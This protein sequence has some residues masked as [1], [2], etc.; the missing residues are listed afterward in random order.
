MTKY[1]TKCLYVHGLHSSVNLEKKNILEKYFQNVLALNLNY[2]QQHD[3][4]DI[5]KNL[6]K[7]GAVDFIVGSSFG[8][9]LGFYLSRE[10]QLPS[11]LFNPALYFGYQDKPFIKNKSN[12]SSPFTYFV[13]GEQDDIIPMTTTTKFIKENSVKDN[14]LTVSCSWL[15]H[16][17]D[18]AT[19]EAMLKSGITI[20]LKYK[21][22]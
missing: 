13:M 14:I 3:A 17:I 11:I 1:Y 5:L 6:C 4:Y 20:S 16:R 12:Q 19:F 8:G 9:Y 7:N 10:L 2:P 15:G 18:L 21:Y 22:P